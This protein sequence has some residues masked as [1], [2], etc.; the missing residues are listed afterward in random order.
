IIILLATISVIALND[1]RAKARDARRISDIR[2]IRTALEFYHSDED[3][4]PI[5]DKQII[6]GQK[7]SE[8]L[9]AKTVGAFVTLETPCSQETNY[10]DSVPKDPLIDW[11]YLYIGTAKDY[12]IIFSTEKPSS[13]GLAGQYMANAEGINTK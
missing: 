13:L 1:Q 2:Q 9:C 10:M 8:K 11:Q 5:V 4:Y 6:L 12:Q 3:E 7:G